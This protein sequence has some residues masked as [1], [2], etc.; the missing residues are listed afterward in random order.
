M[1]GEGSNRLI[2]TGEINR[3]GRGRR[4][5]H[6]KKK[7]AIRNLGDLL[8]TPGSGR[9]ARSPMAQTVTAVRLEVAVAEV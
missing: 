4:P 9:Y 1:Y 7:E 5:W 6:G 2:A 8:H 3:S